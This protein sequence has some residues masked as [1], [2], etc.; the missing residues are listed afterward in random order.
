MYQ[1]I[2]NARSRIAVASG[3]FLSSLI[4]SFYLTYL[5]LVAEF[6]N[7]YQVTGADVED[8]LQNAWAGMAWQLLGI[9]D[10]TH[11][12]SGPYKTDSFA[13]FIGLIYEPAATPY[14]VSIQDS[15]CPCRH[16]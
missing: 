4:A 16:G 2:R 15:K 5:Y 13:Y 11:I 7:K 12:T 9:S 14:L 3:I 10:Y 6:Y 8:G 1:Q